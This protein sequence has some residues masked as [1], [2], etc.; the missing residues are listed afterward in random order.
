MNSA[1]PAFRRERDLEDAVEL[2]PWLLGGRF[3]II[4]RQHRRRGQHL[5]LLAIDSDGALHIIELKIG[6]TPRD[7]VAQV[8]HYDEA[9]ARVG[10][11]EV[12]RIAT[13]ATAPMGLEATFLAFFGHPLPQTVN[14]TR[15]I[16][17]VARSFDPWTASSIRELRRLG[18]VIRAYEYE[19][20][21]HGLRL[22]PALPTVSNLYRVRID[23]YLREFWHRFSSEFAG[24]CV[25]SRFVIELLSH[26]WQTDHTGRRPERLPQ[27]GLVGRQLRRI[28]EEHGEWEY[29]SSLPDEYATRE[30]PLARLVP[31]WQ[32]RAP[33]TRVAGYIR[34]CRSQ[35]RRS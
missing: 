4:A 23:P 2:M 24:P 9:L 33:K 18:R 1:I 13:K 12:I 21:E 10:R 3:L 20:L 17:I 34:R 31:D 35:E 27:E 6:E 14:H 15:V 22:L 28:A 25:T 16:T 7:V 8:L 29:S 19:Q 11:A 30:Q 5:D 32:E 26:V